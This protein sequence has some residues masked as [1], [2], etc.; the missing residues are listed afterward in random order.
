QFSFKPAYLT[1]SGKAEYTKSSGSS[2]GGNKLYTSTDTNL[3]STSKYHKMTTTLSTGLGANNFAVSYDKHVRVGSPVVLTAADKD[4]N[5]DA[6]LAFQQVFDNFK[7]S[8]FTAK[9]NHWLKK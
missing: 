8:G 7:P 4:H 1:A 9:Q 3:D 2:N 5:D 6:E